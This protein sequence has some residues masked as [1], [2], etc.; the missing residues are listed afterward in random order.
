[1]DL[2]YISCFPCLWND[3]FHLEIVNILYFAVA[4]PYLLAG[5]L[6]SA[7]SFIPSW[8][9]QEETQV[10]ISTKEPPN[11]AYFLPRMAL[12]TLL[13]ALLIFMLAQHK[14]TLI[15]V[16]LWIYILVVQVLLFYRRE[17]SVGTNI[18]LNLSHSD[19]LWMLGLFIT[20][21]VIGAFALNDIPNI[22]IPD[23]GSFWETARA[24]ATGDLKPDAFDGLLVPPRLQLANPRVVDQHAAGGQEEQLA[25]AR[26]VPAFAGRTAQLLRLYLLFAQQFIYQR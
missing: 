13:F 5:G 18:V 24:I 1:M 6:L 22:M 17:K 19:I 8:K 2:R 21:L 15:L 9:K 4:I 11:W 3:K 10:P 23:E 25:M 12:T 20:G 7:F 26:R 14:Y 16:G